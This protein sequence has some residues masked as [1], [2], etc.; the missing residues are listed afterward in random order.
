[1]GFAGNLKSREAV[2]GRSAISPQGFCTGDNLHRVWAGFAGNLKSREAVAGRSAIS[3]QGFCTG[4]NLHYLL[5]DLGLTHPVR[6]ERQ[7]AD[8]LLGVLRGISHRGHTS[9][10]LGSGALEQ[11]TKYGD[12]DVIWKQALKDLL[13]PGLVDPERTHVL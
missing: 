8:H 3:P 2:A 7:V 5:G 4:D 12:L 10:V 6:L 1:A 11:R 9:P 13:R